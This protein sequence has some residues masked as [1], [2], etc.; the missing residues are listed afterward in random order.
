MKNKQHY[1][2]ALRWFGWI[3]CGQALLSVLLGSRYSGDTGLPDDFIGQYYFFSGLIG[4][5]SSLVLVL[6]L[7]LGLPFLLIAP[8]HRWPKYWIFTY[9]ALLQVLL[10]ADTFVYQQYRFH[11]NG[12]VIDLLLHGEGQVITF[13]H[14][15]MLQIAALISLLFFSSL[16]ISIIINRILPK[17]RHGIIVSIICSGS[18]LS[19]H[20]LYAWASAVNYPAITQQQ[21]R[22]P[23]YLPLTANKLMVKLGVV[24][25]QELKS[26][27][28]QI[29]D[30]NN[31][32]VYPLHTLQCQ[33][34][35]KQPNVLLIVVDTLR[36]DM[37]DHAVMPNLYDFSEENQIFSDH[38]SGSNSTRAGIFSLFYGIPPNYWFAALASQKPAA[39]ISVLQ[40]QQYQLGIFASAVLTEPAFDKT[41]FAS[42]PNLRLR[43]AGSTAADRDIKITEEWR[44][45]VTKRNNQRPFFGFLFYDAVHSYS[46]PANYS[47]PF[48]PDWKEVNQMEL[49]P[50]FDKTPY[51]NR[52]RNSVHFVD[53][54]LKK[55][56][57]D[58]RIKNLMDNT[59]IIVTAD[60]GEEFND[61]GLNYWGHNGNFTA[62]QTHVP[63]IIHWPGK[64]A[65]TS[66]AMTSH[67]DITPT[68]MSEALG[69]KNPLSDY[70]IGSDLYDKPNHD[71]IVMGSYGENALYQ[72]DKITLVDNAGRLSVRT[73]NYKPLPDSELPRATLVPMLELMRKYFQH[74]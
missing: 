10:L 9:N 18:L 23:L 62:T 17:L 34:L 41:V 30:N 60:H 21:A 59:I 35:A 25:A 50:D 27:K 69:C 13:S 61:N 42:V 66:N 22:F 5:F 16:I 8:S 72:K 37:L 51:L 52:Y 47:N 44:D 57:D 7:I 64:A 54:Q 40:Q 49:G 53:E 36:A 74:Q 20:G 65:G 48:Q 11:I 55:V 29:S 33:P 45:W 67:Y 56:L 43:T 32:F 70:S 63:M 4:H 12:M 15:M 38:H 39:L 71:W 26:R 28:V 24:T 2:N 19:A 6:N 68:L 58:I 31:D 1:I 3:I 73:P 46:T 14:S